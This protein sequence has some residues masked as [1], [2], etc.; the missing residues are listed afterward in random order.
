MEPFL[1]SCCPLTVCDVELPFL[2]NANVNIK[3]NAMSLPTLMKENLLFNLEKD[4]SWNCLTFLVTLAF[5]LF[6]LLE[7][8]MIL[9]MGTSKL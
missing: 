7:I 3:R 1:F 4:L 2:K 5:R 8:I 9:G 6:S